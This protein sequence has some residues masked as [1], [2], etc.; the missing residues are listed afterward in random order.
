MPNSLVTQ[1]ALVLFGRVATKFQPASEMEQTA[2][3]VQ[4]PTV[5]EP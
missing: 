1:Q 3:V 2:G 4:Y 5:P